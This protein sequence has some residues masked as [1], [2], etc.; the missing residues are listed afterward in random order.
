MNNDSRSLLA[1]SLCCPPC[2]T[3]VPS[4][5]SSYIRNEERTK[6]QTTYECDYGKACL[7]FL[8][9]LDS[10]TPSQVHDYLQSVSYKGK[11]SPLHTF[12]RIANA[13]LNML[14]LLLISCS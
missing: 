6:K 3:A 4:V 9:I 1:D 12:I 11:R 7:D 8:T 13:F 10:F 2:T 14:F 5:L